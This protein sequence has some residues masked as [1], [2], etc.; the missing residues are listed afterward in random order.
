MADTFTTNLNLTKPEVGASTDTWGTK[1][2]AD[3]DSLDAIFASNGTSVA[4]NLDGA[5][6]D[7]SVIGGTTPAAGTFTTLTANTSITGTL[8]TAAQTNITS[9]GALNGGSITSGF[10]SINNGSSAITT[11]GTITYGSLSDGTITIANFIDD[12]T[13]GTA[14]ATTLATSE[15]IKA[16]VNSQVATKDTL[17]E[18]LAG[19]NTTGGNDILFADNDKAIFG[20]GSDLQIYHDGTNSYIVN[21]TNDLIIGEDTRVRIKTPSLLV[22]NASDTENMLTATEN[23]AVTLYYDNSPKIATTS[24]GIDVTGTATMDGLTVDGG[25]STTLFIN[26]STNATGTAN[27][28][29]LKFGFGHSGSPDATGNIKLVEDSNNSFNGNM[30]FSVPSNNGSGGS[31][32]AEA[33][34]IDY[35]GNVGIGTSSPSAPLEVAGDIKVSSGNLNVA[36]NALINQASSDSTYL[37]VNHSSSGDGGI[38]LQRANANKWQITSN[39]SHHLVLDSLGGG[40]VLIPSG[41]VGIGASP[42][43]TIRND[44]TSAEKALQIGNRAMF[45]SDGGVTTDLQNNSHLDN[46]NNRVAMQ[47]DLGSL[48]QQYQG[49]HKWFNAASVSAGATQTMTE[50]MRIDSSG[51]LLVGTTT[52]AVANG[53]NT[54]IAL[55]SG[56]QLAIGANND[57]VAYLNRI[58]TDGSIIELRK[59]GSAIGSIGTDSTDIYIGT[60]DT[61]IRFN[62]A[63]NSVLPYNTSTGQTDA[64][65]DLGFSSVRWKDLHLSGTAYV[66]TSVGIGTSSPTVGKLQVNDGSGAITAITRTSGSTSGDLGTIRFGNTDIDSNLVNIVAFQDGATNSGALKFETQA[67]GGATAERMRI[68]SSGK[69]LVGTSSSSNGQVEVKSTTTG[70]Y[71]GYF[72]SSTANYQNMRLYSDVGG[73]ETETFRIENDG[74]VKN[75]NNSY[76]SLSDERIKQDITD[77]N[78]QWE[79]IKNLK[80]VNYKRKDHV[81]EGLDVPMIGVIAQDLEEA[82]M[83]GLVSESIPSTGEIRA[84]SEFG[85]LEDIVDEDGNIEGVKAIPNEGVTV[86]SVKYSVL[87]MKAIKAL[88]ECMDKIET[89][90]SEISTLKGE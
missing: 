28:A 11:T 88:Q 82:G 84:N 78:S 49:I 2:N 83:N 39:T 73:T 61:G 38:L 67:A 66:A 75:T 18:V 48:Y 56:D 58:S 22:N 63:V 20:A 71:K 55:T 57:V 42:S 65:L 6:I 52:A 51:N 59:D 89:L 54:G 46:S 15:S 87:Y 60:T 81:A 86:K 14:S 19:G 72:A 85:T 80:I 47:T 4:L 68:D 17:A 36:G 41:N 77:A 62:D 8:A 13:F 74:D 10:G 27:E 33:M 69:L 23:G 70:S 12:D 35:A 9:V 25:T 32:T 34:R 24:T 50:R 45:F 53:T 21:T 16:Y 90:E 37:K 29:I 3:L 30:V 7:S 79:D 64:T 1:L 5:V 44:I 26:S 76:G 31:S 43:S 40:N